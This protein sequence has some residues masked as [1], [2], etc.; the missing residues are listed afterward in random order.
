[1][2]ADLRLGRGASELTKET[3]ESYHGTQ[4]RFDIVGTTAKGVKIVDDYAHH[5]TEI[6]ATLE[7]IAR[8]CRTTSSG[9]IFQ[10]HTYTRTIALFDDFAE[11]FDK[12]DK[13]DSGG[14]L[15]GKREE[16]LQ[17]FIRTAR[18]AA[19]KQTHP[20]KEVLFMEELRCHRRLCGPTMHSRATW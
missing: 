17:N 20:N 11:A 2:P 5:P 19:F 7:R 9:V 1:M 18:R 6:K 4:R 14:D 13:L 16:Y 15:R 3:L 12:A 8:T 10:P